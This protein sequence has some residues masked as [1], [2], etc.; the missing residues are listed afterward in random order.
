MNHSAPRLD[1]LA[2]V[3]FDGI[4]VRPVMIAQ[5][6]LAPGAILPPGELRIELTVADRPVQVDQQACGGGRV[7][8]RGER[9]GHLPRQF[10]RPGIPAAVGVEQRLPALNSAA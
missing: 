1:Q 6:R 9:V 7:Q 5:D 3:R 10:E 2:D 8:R 4:A